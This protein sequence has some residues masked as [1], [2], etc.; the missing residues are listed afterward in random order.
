MG[1]SIYDQ[2]DANKCTQFTAAAAFN[3]CFIIIG[4]LFAFAYV[5]GATFILLSGMPP[6][7]EGCVEVCCTS[8]GSWLSL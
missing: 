4:F 7:L 2:Y 3:V 6:R 5:F 8:L 1:A